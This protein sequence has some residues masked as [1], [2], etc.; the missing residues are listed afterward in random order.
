MRKKR[1]LIITRNQFG[2]HVDGYY[3]C[4]YLRDRFDITYLCWDYGLPRVA[5]QGVNVKY[6][7][8]CGARVRRYAQF[9]RAA[10]SEARENYDVCFLKYF[11]GCSLLR[12]CNPGGTCVF[13]VRT[14]DISENYFVR[15]VADWILRFESRCFR[16]ITV[17]SESLARKLGFPNNKTYVLPLGA[18]I[19]SDR[20][21]S[22]DE[23]RLLY[24]GTLENRNID[25]T[26]RGFERFYREFGNKVKMEYK[27]IG[28]GYRQEE[29]LLSDMVKEMGLEGVVQVLGYIPHDEL[30]SYFDSQNIGISYIPITEYF[31]CQPP[32]KT[33][34]YILSGMPVIATATSENK[35]VIDAG[36]GVVIQDNALDFYEGLKTILGRKEEYNSSQ[37]RESCKQ[38]TWESIVKNLGVYLEQVAACAGG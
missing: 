31:D 5:M 23:L 27:I 12:L 34:E 35:K 36:N 24:V 14:G 26:V 4:K 6:I 17:I 8:R 11:A 9:L 15:H 33:F 18:D 16:N 30:H 29:K 19:I 13:D 25:E 28:A 37:I 22:L 1:I 7:P 3:Y 38:Y 32:T 21:K 20:D 2:H 10:I